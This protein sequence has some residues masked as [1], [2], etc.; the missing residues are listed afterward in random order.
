MRFAITA[1]ALVG[2]A[3]AS[4]GY[5]Y[6]V[7][8]TTTPVYEETPTPSDVYPVYPTESSSE[9][10]PVYPTET[11]S[12]VYTTKVVTELTTYCPSATEVTY[13]TKTYTVTEAT[14][15]TITDCPCT[16]IETPSYTPAPPSP[17]YPTYPVNGTTVV[18]VYPTGTGVSPTTTAPPEFTGAAAKVGAGVMAVVAAAAAFL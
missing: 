14:T 18:P 9:V 8:S 11:P 16:V 10:Y 13:G 7:N 3:A 1:A 4:Y 6:P 5:G 2:S 15:L 12:D 17:V